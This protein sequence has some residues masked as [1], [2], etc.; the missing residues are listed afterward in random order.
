MEGA[1]PAIVSKREFRRVGE[2]MRSK[3]PRKI[4]PRRVSSS[5]LL[6]GL[7]KCRR[8]RMSLSGHDAKSGKF[9]YYVCQSLLKR[10]KGSCKTPRLNSKRFERLIIDEIRGNILAEDNIRDLVKLVDEEME[11]VSHEHRKKLES[12]ESELAEVQRWLDRLY[13]AIETT[14]LDISD[15][16]PRI[17]EHRERERKLLESARQVEATLA[18]RRVT[19][20]NLET[21]T[22][23]A[24]DMSTYLNEAELTERRAFIQSFVKEISVGPGKATIRYNIPMPED[25]SLEGRATGEVALP[26]PVRY[27]VRPGTPARTRT[28]AHGLGNRCSIRLSYRGL[29]AARLLL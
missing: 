23:F 10:G 4:H 6:S 17:R 16:A 26:G 14:D 18:E 12:I 5:Y 24:G 15:I 3:A 2:L 1:F 22:A 21:I 29:C 27:M 13:R 7:V 19:V 9:S 8:C 25:G 28:G 20:D 11:G